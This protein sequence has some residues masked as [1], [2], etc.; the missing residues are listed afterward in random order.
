[1]RTTGFRG[2]I[3]ISITIAALAAACSVGCTVGA[4]Q[5]L[6]DTALEADDARAE[7]LEAT[8]RVLDKNPAYVDE[9]FGLA[10]KH[11]RT[12]DRFL[13]NAGARLD[14]EEL[15]RMT[16]KHIATNPEGLRVILEQTL[17]A[18][19]DDPAARAAIAQA[20]AA[21][22]A[23]ATDI[24]TDD[25]RVAEA[26][27]EATIDR[28][29]DKPEARLA[30]LRALQDRAPAIAQLV[31]NNPKTLRALMKALLD[32]GLGGVGADLRELLGMPRER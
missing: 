5:D 10:M 1:M 13:A 11:P 27:L 32:V 14:D 16:A 18:A 24:I 17:E 21:R 9:L 2:A 20:I 15:A 12:L 6:V 8:L 30:F 29:A 4:K 31:A 25:A 22:R 26:I 28:L 19:K 7:Y 3:S 23:I